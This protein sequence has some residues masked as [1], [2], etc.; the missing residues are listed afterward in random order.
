MKKTQMALAAVALVASTAA[1]AQVTM[2]GAVDTSVVGG[3]GIN[4][5]MDGTGNWNGTI[6][7]FKGSEDLGGGMK[8]GFA[9]ENGFSAATG[10]QANGGM[11]SGDVTTASGVDRTATRVFNR[12]ANVSLGGEFGTVKLGLQLS[13]FIA[14]SLGGYVNNN[15]SFYVPALVM[16]SASPTGTSGGDTGGFFIP[17]AVSYSVTA[18]GISASVLGQLSNGTQNQE[19]TAATAGT[20]FGDVSVNASYQSRG[21]TADGYTSYNLNAATTVAGLKVAGGYTNHDPK[22][23]AGVTSTTYNVGAQ[24]P[25]TESLNASLQY[26]SS[27]GSKSLANI[28]LQYNLSKSTYVYGTIAQGTNTTVLYAG[29]PASASTAKTGYAIGVV[30]NF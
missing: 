9:L 22:A 13:P 5:N 12:Q 14:G 29:G 17:N 4:A 3:S 19:Y 25:L 23:S 15:E 2:Y 24:Y 16:G 20:S 6:Y 11:P 8:A 7:G 28:G 10:A 21:S 27:T 30:T 1:M 26:A 18:G